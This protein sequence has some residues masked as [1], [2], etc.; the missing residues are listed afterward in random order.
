MIVYKHV[1]PHMNDVMLV[2]SS[3]YNL[4][5]IYIGFMS[6]LRSYYSCTC[7]LCN[8]QIALIYYSIRTHAEVFIVK[9]V[10]SHKPDYTP[11]HSV[12]AET[13]SL[14]QTLLSQKPNIYV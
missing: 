13:T 3:K 14:Q 1:I 6:T 9:V 10:I 11:H 12:I 2:A 4:Y 7:A 8:Q 5:Y